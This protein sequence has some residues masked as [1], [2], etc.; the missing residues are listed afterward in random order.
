VAQC[1]AAGLI[2]AGVSI[3]THPLFNDF[4]WHHLHRGDYQDLA[5][6]LAD[7]SKNHLEGAADR[8]SLEFTSLLLVAFRAYGLAGDL[9]KARELRQDLS[10][11]LE[12]AAIELYNRRNYL[13]A[14]EYIQHL[15]DENPRNWRMRLYRARIR[16]RQEE[17]KQAD[18]ILQKMLEERQEDVGV[19]HA[20]GWSQLK[21]H[22]LQQALE[23]FTQ[24]FARREHVASL[25]DAAECLHRLDRTEE[26]LKLLERAKKQESENAF[27]L[28]LQSQILEDLGQLDSAYEAALLASARDPTNSSMHNRL[29]VIRA[30]QSRP[31]QAIPHFIKAIEL[32]KDMFSPANSLACAY[33]DLGNVDNAVALLPE[34]KAKARTPS[35]GYLL[36]HTEA[37]IALDKKEFDQSREILKREIAQHHNPEPNLGL[38]VR[39]EL[40]SFDDMLESFPLS[41]LLLSRPRNPRSNDWLRWTALTNSSIHCAIKSRHEGQSVGLDRRRVLPWR[42]L[43]SPIPEVALLPLH[44]FCPHLLPAA[45]PPRNR[46]Q[47]SRPRRSHSN[48]H[49]CSPVN[50]A[51]GGNGCPASIVS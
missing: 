35:N 1:A 44:Q 9:N 10:G 51:F 36:R 21:Q 28:D 27:V 30:K 2:T 50:H 43:A 46:L 5:L 12:A 22:H 13:L 23:I 26:A 18:I 42:G 45:H 31:A 49:Y 25:R 15:L 14:D 48:R 38:L 34:L 8:T 20:M 17:W 29:G 6:R 47:Q 11:E 3:E 40:A 39:V 19:L 7:A 33:L 16:I 32:D 24:I 41:P 4:F 37:R